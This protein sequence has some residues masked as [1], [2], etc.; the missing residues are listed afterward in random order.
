MSTDHS[1]LTDFHPLRLEN[2]SG[3]AKEVT[4]PPPQICPRLRLCRGSF[5]EDLEECHGA[6]AEPKPEGPGGGRKSQSNH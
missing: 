3:A 4:T 6:H 5:A 1:W 2:S